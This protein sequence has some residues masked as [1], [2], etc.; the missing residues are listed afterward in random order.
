MINQFRQLSNV[1]IIL[2]FF[3][4]F[5]RIKPQQ[6]VSSLNFVHMRREMGGK[7]HTTQFNLGHEIIEHFI[8]SKLVI[9]YFQRAEHMQ[10]QN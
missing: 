3:F 7:T 4:H 1:R 6:F 5:L 10:K 8:V 9:P 2:Y